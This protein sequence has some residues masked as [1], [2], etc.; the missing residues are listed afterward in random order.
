[1]ALIPLMDDA[2]APEAVRASLAAMPPEATI[3][4]LL[5]HAE[6]VFPP[7]L[8]V[9]G[10]VQTALALDPRARQLAILRV[11]G[12]AG[13]EYERVQH[14]VIAT[15]EGVPAEQV[16]AIAEDRIDGPEFD[17]R[18][19]LL[20]RFVTEAVEQLGASEQTTR[21]LA[22]EL[23]ERELVELLLVIGQYLGL[24]VVLKS[25]AL[26]PQAPLDPAAILAARARR[27]AL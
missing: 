13:C 23:S 7:F 19:A 25:A 16:T 9:A 21:A 10:K 5:A 1:M 4:R 14:E 17:E 12:L 3:W 27:A 18:E 26:E 8:Q 6:T 11:A 24:A 2:D 20:L 15:I 22:A